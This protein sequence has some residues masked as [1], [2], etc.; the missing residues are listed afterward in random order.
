[1]KKFKSAILMIDIPLNIL[2]I[3]FCLWR[4]NM[5]FQ[6]DLQKMIEEGGIGPINQMTIVGGVCLCMFLIFD[7]ICAVGRM[8]HKESI[9]GEGMIG[10]SFFMKLICI[11]GL[12][13]YNLL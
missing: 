10:V 5:M 12:G 7:I 2:G 1:M 3:V 11:I 9:V 13:V 6:S 4:I 8:R